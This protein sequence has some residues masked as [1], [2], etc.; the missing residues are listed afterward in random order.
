MIS[1]SS[2]LCDR[3]RVYGRHAPRPDRFEVLGVG[4][5]GHVCSLFPGHR[6]LNE[7][8]DWIVVEPASP[9]PPP[10]RLTMTLPIDCCGAVCGGSGVRERQGAGGPGGAEDQ[11]SP[12]SRSSWHS[13]TQP[14]PPS[15]WMRKPRRCCGVRAGIKVA[16]AT[17]WSCTLARCDTMPERH[18]SPGWPGIEPRWTTSAKSTVG[19]AFGEASRVW[20][21]TSHGIL[22]EIYYPEVDSACLR[23]AGLLIVR[24]GAS[25]GGEATLHARRRVAFAGSPGLSTDECVHGRPVLNHKRVCCSPDYDVVLQRVHFDARR[26]SSQ[27]TAPLVMASHLGN[28][29]AANT[30]WLGTS[31]GDPVLFAK[32][33][34]LSVAAICDVGWHERT[35]GFVG[36]HDAWNDV[37]THGRLTTNYDRAEMAMWRS[38]PRLTSRRATVASR[39]LSRWARTPIPP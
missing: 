19:T 8:V 18:G 7:L 22:N 23:D 33:D 14:G 10:V 31:K 35:V 30:A 3:T 2:P 32:R 4:E 11:I 25:I 12:P 36:A 6:A 39:S 5:D 16:L 37:M 27:I 29:G 15:S 9:K 24:K 17:S 26:G 38:P 34:G 1:G 28:R 20:F 13:E 21:T